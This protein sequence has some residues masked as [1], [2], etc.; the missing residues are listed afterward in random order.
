VTDQGRSSAGDLPDSLRVET[1]GRVAV[2][3]L[4]RPA[5]RNALSDR[6]IVDRCPRPPMIGRV[7]RPWKGIR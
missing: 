4:A 6:T 7:T 2:L 1:I 3:T 5:E